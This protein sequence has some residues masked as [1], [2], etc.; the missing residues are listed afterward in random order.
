MLQLLVGH[1]RQGDFREAFEGSN[2]NMGLARHRNRNGFRMPV[3]GHDSL[4]FA[5]QNRYMSSI[6]VMFKA[7]LLALRWCEGG[8]AGLSADTQGSTHW[9]DHLCKMIFDMGTEKIVAPIAFV[10]RDE[11]SVAEKF[12]HAVSF[13][14]ECGFFLAPPAVAATVLAFAKK[15]LRLAAQKMVDERLI[16]VQ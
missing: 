11:R 13:F 6:I 12:G 14:P 10:F 15:G 3:Y 7:N 16:I 4:S 1:D 5:L 8:H 9:H 2:R